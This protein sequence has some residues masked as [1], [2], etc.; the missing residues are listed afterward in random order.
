VRQRREREKTTVLCASVSAFFIFLFF[1]FISRSSFSRKGYY[2]SF[3]GIEA[4]ARSR[5]LTILYVHRVV[6]FLV[7]FRELVLLYL[8]VL[9]VL[10][11]PIS[12]SR[13]CVLSSVHALFTCRSSG[14][15]AHV[16]TRERARALA[17]WMLT[18]V[19]AR[20][21]CVQVRMV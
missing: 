5:A 4:T 12:F 10:L 20:R 9:P 18:C 16:H 1:I 11:V 21:V 14:L 3:F 2:Y 7:A 17:N 6:F 8:P 15:C 13:Y 19:S